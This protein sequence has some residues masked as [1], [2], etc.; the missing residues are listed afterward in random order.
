MTRSKFDSVLFDL[1]GTLTNSLPG[2]A[3][4]IQHVLGILGAGGPTAIPSED[5]LRWCVGPPLRELFQR[6]LITTDQSVIEQAVKLYIERYERIGFR[7]SRVFPG[8][9]E[10]LA[11]VS[12]GRRLIL[13]TSKLTESAEKV[14]A[15]FSLR[16]YFEG[17]YGTDHHG[18]PSDKSELV[19]T[20]LKNH[21]CQPATTAIVGDRH[22]DIIAGKTNHLYTIGVTYGYGTRKEL[23][24]ANADQICTSPAEATTALNA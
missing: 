10:M 23:T 2:I 17:V 3:R 24:T 11:A 7:E 13:V 19:Q 14:L 12:V 5:D 8:V 4:S 22:H 16:K 15:E 21:Q 6:L 18:K 9:P 1:D 20:A